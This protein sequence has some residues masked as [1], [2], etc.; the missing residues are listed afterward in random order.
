LEEEQEEWNWASQA[1]Y[2]LRGSQRVDEAWLQQQ[3]DHTRREVGEDELRR[4]VS[5]FDFTPP[6]PPTPPVSPTPTLSDVD[7]ESTFSDLPEEEEPPPLSDVDTESTFSDLPDEED[8]D[9]DDPEHHS[10]VRI[11]DSLDSDIYQQSISN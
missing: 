5:E 3:L 9:E 7:T 8:E 10:E 4:Q 11:Q 1:E 6:T 2:D